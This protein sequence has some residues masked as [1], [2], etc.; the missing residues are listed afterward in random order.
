VSAKLGSARLGAWLGGMLL[1]TC[2]AGRPT[3]VRAD[4]A[5][6]DSLGILLP[7]DQPQRII[8]ATNFGLVLSED[9]G[10]SFHWVCEDAIG[11]FA[12]IYQLGPPPDD[13]LFAVTA[14]GLMLSADN[15]CSWSP[16]RGSVEVASD[17]FADPNDP[18]HVLVVAQGG[19]DAGS[20]AV[21]AVFES[22]DGGSNFGA[23][24]YQTPPGAYIE[25]VEIPRGDP[26]TVYV[27][28]YL[29]EPDVSAQLLRS[30]DGGEH[31]QAHD[32][33]ASIDGLFMRILGVDPVRP[34]I[35][36]LRVLENGPAERFAI[37]DDATGTAHVTL[38][39]GHKI[40]AF[41]RRSDG[42]LIVGTTGEGAYIS[43][44]GGESFD[45]LPNAPHLRGLGERGGRLYAV[46]DDMLDGFAIGMSEDR[47]ASWKPLL[48]FEQIKGP[49]ACGSV[50]TRCAIPWMNLL[51]TLAKPPSPEPSVDAGAP[52]SGERSP[53]G[54]GCGCALPGAA[55]ARRA[56]ALAAIV[57]GLLS[58]YRA[59][60][61]RLTD[62][63]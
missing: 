38:S 13:R 2:T 51:A 41:L 3:V 62:R 52:P 47:G 1:L 11:L 9:D 19:A 44:D 20:D 45:A 35:V 61:R 29:T 14:D 12:T 48:R 23:A 55:R 36:Y 46:A 25:G 59:R 18:L 27:A 50:P 22:N 60:R 26:K 17:V 40:T 34:D 63:S 37:Y 4:G 57:L 31:W 8:A 21:R 53:R 32:V 49:L 15:A 28:L 42:A 30:M 39:T 56:S 43:N 5:F 7:E 24:K 54:G 33:S 58:S 6:P 10:A 16:A